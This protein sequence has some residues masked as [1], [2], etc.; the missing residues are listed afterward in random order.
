MDLRETL[1]VEG[2]SCVR[3]LPNGVYIGVRRQLFTVGLF[4][5]LDET[6]YRYRYCY[7]WE[8]DALAA[9]A[10]WDGCGHPPGPWV[11]IKGDHPESERLGPGAADVY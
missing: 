5:G 1:E 2:Y 9:C 7:E 4:V 11:K 6:G 10:V 3:Q 8:K